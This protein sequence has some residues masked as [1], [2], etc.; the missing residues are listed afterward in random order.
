MN[1]VINISQSNSAKRFSCST[2]N[3]VKKPQISSIVPNE[4]IEP[5]SSPSQ[6]IKIFNNSI[7]FY[8]NSEKF[9]QVEIGTSKEND[10]EDCVINNRL[11]ERIIEN[12]SKKE[13][14]TTK[15][16]ISNTGIMTNY[17]SKSLLGSVAHNNNIVKNDFADDTLFLS[18]IDSKKEKKPS[19]LKTKDLITIINKRKQLQVSNANKESVIKESNKKV[20]DDGVQTSF[21]FQEEM[22]V[23]HTN[24][25]VV[26]EDNVNVNAPTPKKEDI[27]NTLNN[28]MNIEHNEDTV[29]ENNFEIINNDNTMKNSITTTNLAQKESEEFNKENTSIDN[30]N[31]SQSIKCD[32][33]QVEELDFDKFRQQNET[34]EINI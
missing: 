27:N 28:Y 6:P 23:I 10:N 31:I 13:Y 22:F 19:G 2:A 26:S 8:N 15:N 7:R 3:Y 9:Q 12:N 16:M 1:N 33:T 17:D 24:P 32:E 4:L 14:S 21:I 34:K 25:D 11:S 20:N 18:I 5:K 29:T 30:N